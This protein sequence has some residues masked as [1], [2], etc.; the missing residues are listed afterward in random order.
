LPN[1]EI[2]KPITTG[3]LI[4]DGT[5]PK[6]RTGIVFLQVITSAQ[7]WLPSFSDLDMISIPNAD[8]KVIKQ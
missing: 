5:D 8:P 6:I 1:Q 4:P 2:E 7:T 3:M